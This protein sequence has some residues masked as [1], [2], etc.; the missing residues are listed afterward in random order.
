MAIDYPSLTGSMR[1][2]R[3]PGQFAKLDP[4]AAGSYLA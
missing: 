2:W 4:G 1:S 3:R